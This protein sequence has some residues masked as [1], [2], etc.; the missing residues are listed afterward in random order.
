[1]HITTAKVLKL[2]VMLTKA[3]IEHPIGLTNIRM[4]RWNQLIH[5]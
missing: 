5:I 3:V 2:S 1:M 4:A